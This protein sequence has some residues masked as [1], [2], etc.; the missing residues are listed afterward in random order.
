MYAIEYPASL[1]RSEPEQ[2]REA[3]RNAKH[4]IKLILGDPSVALGNQLFAMVACEDTK[5]F[6]LETTA[7]S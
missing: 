3:L 4:G 5:V 1:P 7:N 6:E 2:R